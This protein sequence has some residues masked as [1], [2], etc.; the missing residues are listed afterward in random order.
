MFSES[1]LRERVLAM[2]G[3]VRSTHGDCAEPMLLA[4]RLGLNVVISHSCGDQDGFHVADVVILGTQQDQTPER[5]RFTLYHEICHHLLRQDEEFWSELHDWV[6]R[7]RD[8]EVVVERLCNLGAAEFLLPRSC[9]R[10]ILDTEGASVALIERLA[11]HFK[12]SRL[13]TAIQI[14]DCASHACIFVVAARMEAA[15]IRHPRMLSVGHSGPAPLLVERA[16]PSRKARYT[17]GR[18]TPIRRGS[19]IADAEA[20]EE[21]H[22]IL[23]RDFVPFRSGKKWE[24]DAEAVRLGTRVYSLF[25]LESPVPPCAGQLRLL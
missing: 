16:M 14:V 13:A 1:D 24:V 7:D 23:E 5:V 22:I 18:H 17:V 19:I 10:P 2:V 4:R 20:A 3:G 21:G 8:F 9:I 11:G 12:A 6:V 25:H 15:G